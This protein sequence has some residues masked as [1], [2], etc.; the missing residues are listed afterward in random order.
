LIC[1]A[2]QEVGRVHILKFDYMQRKDIHPEAFGKF[3][4]QARRAITPQGFAKAFF[5]ANQ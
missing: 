1:A 4:P 2:E 5:K 3:N